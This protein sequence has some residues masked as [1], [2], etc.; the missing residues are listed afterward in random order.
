MNKD[1]QQFWETLTQPNKKG[2]YNCVFNKDDEDDCNNWGNTACEQ[3]L[4]D[5]KWDGETYDDGYEWQRPRT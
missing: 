3:N 5:W 1:K 4:E 2:C